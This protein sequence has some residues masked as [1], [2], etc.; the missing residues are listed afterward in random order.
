M[1]GCV[2]G[3]CK[4]THLVAV[5]CQDTVDIVGA[6]GLG[7]V[8]KLRSYVA[9]LTAFVDH[10]LDVDRRGH[11]ELFRGLDEVEVTVEDSRH[12]RH[13][14]DDGQCLA[15]V[16]L[17]RGDGD[18][19]QS[20]CVFVVGEDLQSHAVGSLH[21]HVGT[22]TPVA[23]EKDI[24]AVVDGKLLVGQY[25]VVARNVDVDAVV[26]HGG[27]ETE[28]QSELVLSVVETC[29]E[30]R[31]AALQG[32]VE[33][34][35]EDI[36]GIFLTIVQLQCVGYVVESRLDAQPHG[37]YL[38]AVV[39]HRVGLHRAVEAEQGRGTHVHLQVVEV[40][41]KMLQYAVDDVLAARRELDAQIGE[42]PAQTCFVD[43]LVGDLPLQFCHEG[44]AVLDESF[45]AASAIH[46]EVEVAAVHDGVGG[47]ARGEYVEYH[48]LWAIVAV[49]LAECDVAEHALD[50]VVLFQIRAHVDMSTEPK[51][52]RLVGE[53]QCVEVGV[54]E[55]A[56]DG[57]DKRVAVELRVDAYES[58]K[59]RVDAVDMG[60]YTSAAYVGGGFDAAEVIAGVSKLLAVDFCL[61]VGTRREEVGARAVGSQRA[62]EG[63]Q[64]L[65]GKEV[66]EG[67]AA[68]AQMGFIGQ[69][70][71]GVYGRLTAE[72]TATLRGN[73]CRGIARS[74]DLDAS[75]EA[76]AIGQV[77]RLWQRVAQEPLH[78]SQII[79]V[80]FYVEISRESFRIGQTAQ[81]TVGGETQ[82]GGDSETEPVEMQ[83]LEVAAE[84]AVDDQWLSGQVVE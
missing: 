43:I 18:V 46:V 11:R 66:V 9:H 42:Q 34:G 62:G 72:R 63:M 6:V 24:V 14:G 8:G 53:M 20:F 22:D 80:G 25:W 23:V 48:F 69:C 71:T 78:G 3:T 10:V 81:E 61:Y 35:V 70:A 13:V 33:E 47:V 59:Q 29:G 16:E 68:C 41:A 44:I 77:N 37:V 15:E 50:V 7:H 45:I 21:L 12:I 54:G 2:I 60:F 51:G 27:F 32:A 83:P 64:T 17:M 58:L 19:L 67:E 4:R 84:A 36:L 79:G 31:A 76:N 56:G 52:D 82:Q 5:V 30:C 1:P 40:V 38:H 65:T 26:L 28:A 74:V 55:I 73:E 39:D 57:T 75:A 49:A